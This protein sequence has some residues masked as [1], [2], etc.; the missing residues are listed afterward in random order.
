MNESTYQPQDDY[1]DAEL[2]HMDPEG[3]WPRCVICG[4]SPDWSARPHAEFVAENTTCTPHGVQIDPADL[5]PARPPAAVRSSGY[6]RMHTPGG[7]T[8]VLVGDTYGTEQDAAEF[9]AAEREALAAMGDPE[10]IA[11]LAGEQ[12]PCAPQD[13]ACNGHWKTNVN[14]NSADYRNS[15]PLVTWNH[16]C[17]RPAG[18]G[19]LPPGSHRC[20]CGASPLMTSEHGGAAMTCDCEPV[21]L[22]EIAERL[23][24]KRD[25][26]DHWRTRGLLPEPSW[27][28]GGRPC[29][30]WSVIEA[31]ARETGRLNRG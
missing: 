7:E 23:G 30:P 3:D 25:T 29:W 10:C 4:W 19:G 12:G 22:A 5:V 18:H 6:E 27:T 15:G 2:A 13:G 8:M 28:V 9:A 31:W 20:I 21:G 1:S 11:E 24:I 26:A 14:H 16:Y 17:A